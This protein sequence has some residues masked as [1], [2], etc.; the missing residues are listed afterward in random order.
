MPQPGESVMDVQNSTEQTLVIALPAQPYL[1]NELETTIKKTSITAQNTIVDFSRVVV[2]SS[3]T[4]CSLMIL[5]RLLNGANRQLILCAVPPNIMGVFQ[6]VGL[7]G[8][9]VCAAD[10]R[11]ARTWLQRHPCPC[12]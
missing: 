3:V 2:M 12:P 8:L 5:E 6:R 9:F 4:I 1:G 11:A 10:E 7:Q